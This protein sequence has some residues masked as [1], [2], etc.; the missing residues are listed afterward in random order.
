M[1]LYVEADTGPE[2]AHEHSWGGKEREGPLAY[3][4]GFRAAPSGQGRTEPWLKEKKEIAEKA[5]KKKEEEEKQEKAGSPSPRQE[6]PAG[7]APVPPPPP[8]RD[9]VALPVRTRS[10]SPNK[11]RSSR[12][13]E[14]AQ[15]QQSSAS[16]SSSSQWYPK[17]EQRATSWGGWKQSGW[18]SKGRQWWQ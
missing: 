5:A 17:E 16:A 3:T 2:K 8:P 14:P 13:A 1:Y 15:Q 11:M 10:P 18:S 12:W 9:S 4:M 6:T 7:R